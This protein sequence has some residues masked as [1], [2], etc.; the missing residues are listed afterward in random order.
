MLSTIDITGTG[1]TIRVF[2]LPVIS[3]SNVSFWCPLKP[4]LYI[5]YMF[6]SNIFVGLFSIYLQVHLEIQL[7]YIWCQQTTELWASVVFRERLLL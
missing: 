6:Y 2:H 7:D 5:Q 4:A 3:F 1:T